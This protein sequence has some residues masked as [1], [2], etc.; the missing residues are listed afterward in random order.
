MAA[1]AAAINCAVT[2]MRLPAA[3]AAFEHVGDVEGLGDPPDV[4]LFPRNANAD[5]RA[6]TFNPDDLRQQ[7]DDLFGQAIAE[8]ILILSALMLAKGSTAIDGL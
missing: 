7:V 3:H 6:M 1:V 5:V 4:F 2:R 8:V